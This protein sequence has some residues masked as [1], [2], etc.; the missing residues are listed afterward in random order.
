M[1]FRFEYFCK[2]RKGRVLN[3][4]LNV[5]NYETLLH[6]ALGVMKQD[7]SLIKDL[8]PISIEAAWRLG[9]WDLLETLLHGAAEGGLPHDNYN[10]QIGNAFFAM[11]Q[12][13]SADFYD[14]LGKARISVMGALSAASMESYERTR[15][16]RGGS[17]ESCCT[18]VGH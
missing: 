15:N 2:P 10:F 6:H 3:C 13:R 7:P 12:Q 14:A 1:R 18:A 11:Q 16:P 17:E 9:K 5:G 4:L 8:S